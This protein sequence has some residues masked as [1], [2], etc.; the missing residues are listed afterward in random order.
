MTREFST[1]HGF[2]LGG[3]IHGPYLLNPMDMRLAPLDT[4]KIKVYNDC[5][6]IP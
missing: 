3:S 5:G 2:G 1:F 6:N 4:A